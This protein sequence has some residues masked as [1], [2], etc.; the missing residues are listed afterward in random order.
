MAFSQAMAFSKALNL[1]EPLFQIKKV[2]RC[3]RKNKC[4]CL[5]T[6]LDRLNRSTKYNNKTI[7]LMF[8]LINVIDFCKNRFINCNSSN[9][10]Q[11]SSC[12]GYKRQGKLLST[13]SISLFT[14][15]IKAGQSVTSDRT[16]FEYERSIITRLGATFTTFSKA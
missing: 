1:L 3:L 6:L 2:G 5:V 11:T 13:Q 10:F 16:T 9:M 7:N 14:S 4:D 15:N 8:Y 12:R